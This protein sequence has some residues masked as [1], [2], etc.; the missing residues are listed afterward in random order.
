LI[1]SLISIIDLLKEYSIIP[2]DKEEEILNE[3]EKIKFYDKLPNSFKKIL[4]NAYIYDYIVMKEF[5]ILHKNGKYFKIILSR[6]GIILITISLLIGI[7]K[8]NFIEKN[9]L[10]TIILNDDNN[11]YLHIL[12]LTTKNGVCAYNKTKK[13]VEFIPWENIKKIIFLSENP[14]SIHRL[15]PQNNKDIKHN[16]LPK[17]KKVIIP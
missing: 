17:L 12:F 14:Y 2:A 5:T 11:T 10:A 6:L 1:F 9:N 13:Y 16:N 7:G 3:I 15:I 8:A 4:K